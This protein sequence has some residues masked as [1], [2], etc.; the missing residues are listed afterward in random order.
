MTD[1]EEIFMKCPFCGDIIL[2]SATE[3]ELNAWLDQHILEQR[4]QQGTGK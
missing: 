2:K 1:F 4:C 3:N